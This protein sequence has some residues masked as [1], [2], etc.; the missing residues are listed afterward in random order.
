MVSRS[1]ILQLK[2]QMPTYTRERIQ[3][4]VQ[5]CFPY[6][7]YHSCGKHWRQN[8]IRRAFILGCG[9]FWPASWGKGRS[10]LTSFGQERFHKEDLVDQPRWFWCRADILGGGKSTM[11]DVAGK[12]K[13][14][15][16][17]EKMGWQDFRQSELWAWLYRFLCDLG[18][19]FNLSLSQFTNL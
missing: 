1:F 2:P 14:S 17:T 18:H 7:Q 11:S 10:E 15:G 16:R 12:R 13:S 5:Q 19:V 4:S 3:H 9:D 8:Q 6:D